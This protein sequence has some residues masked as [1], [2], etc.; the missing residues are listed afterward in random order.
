[1][2]HRVTFLLLAYNQESLVRESALASLAQ[3]CEPL[4]IIFSDDASSDGTFEVLKEVADHYIGIH[5]V[6]VRRNLKN[7]GVGE[8]LNTLIENSDSQFFIASA[9]DD[10]SVPQRARRLISAWDESGGKLDLVS[11]HCTRMLYDGTLAE[12]VITADLQGLT[13]LSWA[14]DRPYIVGATHA[15]TRRLHE[16][17]GRFNS[18]IGREDQ[19]MVFR[20]LC[21]GGAVTLPEKLVHYRDGGFARMSENLPIERQF[22]M[23]KKNIKLDRTEMQ[24][25][26][27]DAAR[28]VHFEAVQC[29]FEVRLKK[30]IFA[31]NILNS[32]NIFAMLAEGIKHEK[33]PWSW[34]F[35]KILTTRFFEFYKSFQKYNKNRRH[36]TKKIKNILGLS[37]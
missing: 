22:L 28:T 15:F 4:K 18:D 27:E 16:K 21:A 31:E 6:E 33:L 12:T 1:M 30:A 29:I 7:L 24:Q 25:L 17:F 35:K 9:G 10:I 36:F 2:N 26:L 14:Q 11:S 34:R 3:D 32:E 37:S 23:Y 8:H 5:T 20:A 13:P 19:I